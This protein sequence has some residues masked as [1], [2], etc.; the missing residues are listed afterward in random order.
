MFE[1]FVFPMLHHQEF[2]RHL[3]FRQENELGEVRSRDLH[4]LD[5]IKVRACCLQARWIYQLT[6]SSFLGLIVIRAT[7]ALLIG[8]RCY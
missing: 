4:I 2:V 8:R 5:F 3:L 1:S 7:I 6:A